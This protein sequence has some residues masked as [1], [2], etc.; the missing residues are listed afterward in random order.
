[1][2]AS[3]DPTHASLLSRR[4]VIRQAGLAAAAI[5]GLSACTNYGAPTTGEPSSATTRASGGSSSNGGGSGQEAELTAKAAEIPVGSGTI[6]PEAQTVITQPKAGEFK[7]FT[8]VCTHQQ[9]IVATVTDTINCNCHGS[10]FSITDGSVVNPPA[11]TP[12]A[13]KKVTV[14]GDTVSVA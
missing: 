3:P 13:A 5:A 1:V 10:K 2:I 8:A 7:A 6:F 9:C 4:T 12:L 14:T 11:Q